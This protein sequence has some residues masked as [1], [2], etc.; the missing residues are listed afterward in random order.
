MIGKLQCIGI[1]GKLKRR[2][3]LCLRGELDN[4]YIDNE[5]DYGYLCG[6]INYAESLSI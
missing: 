3:K 5:A 4:N 6:S 2:N 1:Y